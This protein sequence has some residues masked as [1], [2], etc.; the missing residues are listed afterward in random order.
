MSGETTA[1]ANLRAAR[2]LIDAFAAA[3]V[4]AAVLSPGARS[5]PLA[6]A[7]DERRDIRTYVVTDERS[8]AFF[9][10]GIARESEIP[11][12]LVCTSGTAAANYTPAVAE[13]SLAEVPLLVVTADRPPEARG[14]G[15]A[16]TIRQTAMFERHVRA[17]REAAVPS[18]DGPPPAYYRALAA[19]AYASALGVP[20]GPVHV[21]V[22]L[23][24]PLLP[25]PLPARE[26]SAPTADA[27]GI[28]LAVG[29]LRVATEQLDALAARVR[30]VERGVIVCGPSSRPRAT[31]TAV[32]ALAA[33][34]GWPVLADPLSGMRNA[35]LDDGLI[36]EPHDI[37]LRSERFRD[38]Q[39]PDLVL[40]LGALPTSK[41]LQRALE[42]WRCEHVLFT[43][44]SEWPDPRWLATTVVVCDP[45][46][47]AADLA[48][49]LG[50]GSG[51]L[52][53]GDDS[54]R[55]AWRDAARSARAALARGLDDA[56]ATFEGRAA[57]DVIQ[58]LP[59]GSVIVVG[60]SMPIRDVDVFC[61]SISSDVT[62]LGNRG[63]NGIDGLLSTAL[64]TAAS[65][66][67][68]TVLLLGDLSFLHDVG[69]LQLAA[70]H[71]LSLLVVVLDNDGGGIFQLLPCAELGETF[72]RCFLTPH[73][74]DLLDAAKLGGFD[75]ARVTSDG[76]L[77]RAV[78]DWAARPR[79]MLVEVAC[80]RRESAELRARL[81][82]DAVAAVDGSAR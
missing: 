32:A 9:A 2:A 73:G 37:V 80:E 19:S 14:F 5:G 65:S 27:D 33:R 58:A 60:N 68:P 6:V 43:S 47:A 61:A 13:A 62:V 75:T 24:E 70:R 81:I 82:A 18:S 21:N 48:A 56:P 76:D 20:R 74:L 16:Q 55:S 3:G 51:R 66:G 22:P 59:A 64:G 77:E 15:A 17:S 63:A 7:L 49:R 31:R 46:A 11:P 52:R 8:A 10:L 69:A 67:A 4:R 23:R 28:R 1:S 12:L 30:A 53:A 40:R 39:R 54:W 72:E 29:E 26:P 50:T 34:T 41:S 45:I 71:R 25:I 38:R 79:G 36:V 42:T 44:P 57:R 78:A 35:A